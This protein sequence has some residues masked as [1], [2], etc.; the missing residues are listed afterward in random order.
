MTNLTRHIRT[1]CI[2]GLIVGS[3]AAA[4]YGFNS[5]DRIVLEAGIT[6]YD[7]EVSTQSVVGSAETIKSELSTTTPLTQ[8]WPID[9]IQGEPRSWDFNHQP[10][11]P[12]IY[13]TKELNQDIVICSRCGAACKVENWRSAPESPPKRV[14][15]SDEYDGTISPVCA[16]LE[17]LYHAEHYNIQCTSCTYTR[18]FKKM[19]PGK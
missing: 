14:I 5:L 17:M 13:H 3:V 1:A 8:T 7:A 16:T 6:S 15:K 2:G 18:Y 19:M 4:V 12:A 11:E 9:D 10:I